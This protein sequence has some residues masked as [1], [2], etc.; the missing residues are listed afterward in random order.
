MTA[1]VRGEVDANLLPGAALGSARSRADTQDPSRQ[2]RGDLV[3]ALG[4][5]HE[6]GVEGVGAGH[7]TS[8]DVPAE[9]PAREIS[10]PARGRQYSK[11]SSL[12]VIDDSQSPA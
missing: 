4:A 8:R 10:Y 9:A 2:D 11:N 6:V 12:S 7:G 1:S 3:E 5:G